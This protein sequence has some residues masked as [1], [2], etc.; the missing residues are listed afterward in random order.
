L[1]GSAFEGEPAPPLRDPVDL[2]RLTVFAG[3]VWALWAGQHQTA[4]EV[5][6]ALALMTV[7]RLLS[8]PR[9]FDLAFALGMTLDAWGNVVGL[10][11]HYGW[12]DTLVHFTL[13]MVAAPTAYLALARLEILPSPELAAWRRRYLGMAVITFLIGAGFEAVYEIY[14]FAVDQLTGSQLQTGNADTM[15]DLLASSAGALVGG[16]LLLA[17]ASSAVAPGALRGE[18]S[19]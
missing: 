15:V 16:Q 6:V 13:T 18:E 4:M 12:F 7:P 19:S 3:L 8:L 1:Q 11:G 14:E 17:W 5:A 10:F 2:V 9:A